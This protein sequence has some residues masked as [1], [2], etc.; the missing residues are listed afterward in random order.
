MFDPFKDFDS[1]GYLRNEFGFKEPT[2]IQQ[3][4]HAMFRAGL[5]EA[6]VFIANQK[7]ITYQHFLKVH[8][9]LFKEFYPWAGSDRAETAPECAISKAEIMF[10]HP[11]EVR[12]AVDHG[13]TLGQN[14]SVMRQSPG[15]VMG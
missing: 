4:E 14:I 13:L 12:L 3:M 6:L 11:H 2:Q 7:T 9:I 8:E 1:K 15:E 5:D 10:A